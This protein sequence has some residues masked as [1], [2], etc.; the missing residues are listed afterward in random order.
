IDPARPV[1]FSTHGSGPGGV[2]SMRRRSN[3][4]AA[5]AA[6]GG[7]VA[8]GAV[9]AGAVPGGATVV[10]A[11]PR[12]GCGPGGNIEAIIDDSGSMALT[13]SS[14]LRVK[15]LDL[16]INS[17]SPGTLL[18]AVEFGGTFFGSS[19]SADT[20]FAPEAV[21]PNAAAMKAEL[22]SKIKADN[23]G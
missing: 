6:A 3:A 5:V 4:M 17:L 21:G 14:T 18:G 19:P 12:G 1:A 7:V 13:D 8:T 20:V 9:A 22:E 16:L 10:R 23:G 2:G 11:P 15:G